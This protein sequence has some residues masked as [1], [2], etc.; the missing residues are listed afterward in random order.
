MAGWNIALCRCE[1]TKREESEEGERREDGGIG[2]GGFMTDRRKVLWG[3]S[4]GPTGAGEP[5]QRQL[6]VKDDRNI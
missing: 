1:V 6:R 5:T 4:N 2:Q 3:M